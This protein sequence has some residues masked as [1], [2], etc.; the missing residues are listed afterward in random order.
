MLA[1]DIGNSRLKWALFSNQCIQ[2]YGAF[3]YN[4]KTFATQL[5][6]ESIPLRSSVVEISCV[7]GEN[8]KKQL[9]DWLSNN[10][11]KHVKF[12]RTQPEQCNITN[13]Y[14]VPGNLGIDRWLAMIAAFN[15]L[16]RTENERLCVI[17]CGTAI[18]LDVVGIDGS[19]HGGLII[20][21]LQTMI[22][23]LTGH[24]S[25]ECT[26]SDIKD[27][28]INGL[29]KDTQKAVAN[30]CVQLIV[31]GITG[32]VQ[33]IENSEDTS[34]NCVVTGGDGEL[35]SNAL[36]LSTVYKPHLVL[37]GLALAASRN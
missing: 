13:S 14:Q 20:P 16:K 10:Q 15:L 2:E 29:G 18:T 26:V 1:I 8:I 9:I 25:I 17:D 4:S 5:T 11:Q 36:K 28:L 33:N 35:I 23:S 22:R 27:P 31:E 12:A 19:H 3:S 34:L 21:G 30:G 6:Q 37:Q 7:A 24:T 32:I